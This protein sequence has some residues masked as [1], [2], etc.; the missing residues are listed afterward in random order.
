MALL[1]RAHFPRFGG[2]LVRQVRTDRAGLVYWSG[3]ETPLDNNPLPDGF[4]YRIDPASGEATTLHTFSQ[5]DVGRDWWGAFDGFQDKIFVGT[6][7]E[8]TTI[9]DVSAS[10]VRHIC[11]LP[12]AATA[13]SLS[14]RRRP[15]RLQ[16]QGRA[17]LRSRSGARR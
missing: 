13:F 7:R 6:S 1:L 8:K 2:G 9:Y 3:L 4:I 12:F 17:L 5:A 14:R 10:P 15:I 16:R 11:Q